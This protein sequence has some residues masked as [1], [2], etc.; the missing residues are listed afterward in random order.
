MACEAT[1][2]KV[3]VVFD[4]DDIDGCQSGPRGVW[5]TEELAKMAIKVLSCTQPYTSFKYEEFEVD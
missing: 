4:W 2:S 1:L 5:S 3:W